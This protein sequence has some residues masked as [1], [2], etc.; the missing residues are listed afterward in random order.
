M[1][2]KNPWLANLTRQI[3][4]DANAAR[5]SDVIVAK[6]RD[7]RAALQ[8]IIGPAGV[9]ALYSRSLHVAGSA[10]PWLTETVGPIP[11]REDLP[12]LRS[13]IAQQN[14][15]EAAAGGLLL[16]QTFNDLLINLIGRSLT[17]QLLGPIWVRP[18]NRNADKDTLT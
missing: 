2:H 1:D 10:Y 16:L 18:P 9:A 17:D 15:A 4:P 14:S 6:V 11:T 13:V 12:A 5:V 7:I 8:A 3:G